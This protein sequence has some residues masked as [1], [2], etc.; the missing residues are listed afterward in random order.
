MLPADLKKWLDQAGV[1]YRVLSVSAC[2]SGHWIAPL[3]GPGTLV[4]S[5]ADATHTSFG[6]GQDADLTYFGRAVFDEQ[7]RTSTRSFE[8]AHAAA[9]TVIARRE[10]EGGKEDG[11]SNPQIA[12]G[13]A[14]RA[15]LQRLESQLP[16]SAPTP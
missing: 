16:A 3:A 15:Q 13:N 11:Y 8:Q 5:A 4:M 1:K 12:V 7:L 6:C 14:M 10:K 2:F 9:R